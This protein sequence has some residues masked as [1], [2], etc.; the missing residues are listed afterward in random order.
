M[1]I[2]YEAK[3]PTIGS[4]DWWMRTLINEPTQQE[5][6]ERARLMKIVFA[7]W[8]SARNL[9]PVEEGMPANFVCG[10]LNDAAAALMSTTPGEAMRQMAYW[11]DRK[12]APIDGYFANV[13]TR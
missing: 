7:S 12:A 2:G 9:G 13:W 4:L 10:C 11:A 6:E 1:E 3:Q 5:R 8:V